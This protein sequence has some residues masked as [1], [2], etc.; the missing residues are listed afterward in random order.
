MIGGESL[1][2]P[3][4]YIKK[5]RG[6][7]IVKRTEDETIIYIGSGQKPTGGY[8][9]TVESV[10][11]IEG[12]TKIEVFEKGPGPDESVT[13]AITSPYVV[14]KVFKSVSNIEAINNQ[15]DKFKDINDESS[16]ADY[17]ERKQ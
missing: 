17:F 13:Q 3:I 15:G 12:V 2:E 7:G 4:G 1:K 16:E 6:F 5:L 8:N 9:I 10:R 11:K 14:I